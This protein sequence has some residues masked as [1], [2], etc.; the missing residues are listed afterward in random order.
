MEAGR[1]VE[2]GRYD[3]LMAASDRFRSLALVS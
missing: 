2:R 3:E 1:I